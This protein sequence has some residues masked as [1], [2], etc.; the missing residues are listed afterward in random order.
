MIDKYTKD[1]AVDGS[2]IQRELGEIG[3]QRPYF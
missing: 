1:I 2:L 3:G